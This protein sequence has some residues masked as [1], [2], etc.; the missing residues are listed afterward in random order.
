M[1]STE[2][3]SYSLFHTHFMH[4]HLPI[5]LQTEYAPFSGIEKYTRLLKHLFFIF[6]F[7]YI[8]LDP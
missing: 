5:Q 6:R 7:T 4:Y 2:Y 3:Q 1:S 8:K